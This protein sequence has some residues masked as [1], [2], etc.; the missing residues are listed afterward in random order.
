[1]AVQNLHV[2]K[3]STTEYQPLGATAG[4]I[5]CRCAWT[6]GL[7][8]HLATAGLIFLLPGIP[9]AGTGFLPPDVEGA[10]SQA[11]SRLKAPDDGAGE[12][13][14]KGAGHL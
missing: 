3:Q 7:Q 13:C 1:M 2:L 12:K 8:R 6:E 11:A 4:N 5:R 14:R 9:Q 10:A